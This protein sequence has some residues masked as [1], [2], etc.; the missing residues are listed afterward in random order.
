MRSY[1]SYSSPRCLSSSIKRWLRSRSISSILSLWSVICSVYLALVCWRSN[2]S[3]YSLE[4]SSR[5]GSVSSRTSTSTILTVF[6]NLVISYSASVYLA[7]NLRNRF[8]SSAVK[9]L[10]SSWLAPPQAQELA[11]VEA[12]ASSNSWS[13]A[14]IFFSK[15]SILALF[16]RSVSS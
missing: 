4:I 5:S 3:F 1:S 12:R 8:L 9:F 7:F 15:S 13:F 10:F 11:T 14:R 16:L 2:F 6:V